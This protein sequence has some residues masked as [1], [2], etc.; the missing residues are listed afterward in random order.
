MKKKIF[1]A[2][3]IIFSLG[4]FLSNKIMKRK[5]CISEE[6]LKNNFL[7]NLMAMDLVLQ[8]EDLYNNEKFAECLNI[9]NQIDENLLTKRGKSWFG[10]LEKALRKEIK[11]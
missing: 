11:C 2:G 5:I 10:E 7:S 4:T 1:F 3:L 9:I 8:A 6:M